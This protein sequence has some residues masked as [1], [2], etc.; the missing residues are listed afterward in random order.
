MNIG[1]IGRA[2]GPQTQP[3]RSSLKVNP[4]PKV[5]GKEAGRMATAEDIAQ[6]NG[7]TYDASLS[8]VNREAVTGSLI[9]V[10]A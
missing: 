9:S 6:D 7:Q 1:N 4:V 10:Y 5:E 3:L 2:Y 8:G